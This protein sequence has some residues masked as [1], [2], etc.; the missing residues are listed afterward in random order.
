VADRGAH[1]GERPPLLDLEATLR[2]FAEARARL[3]L[4]DYD[5]TLV[6]F[7]RTPR[8]AL[9]PRGLVDVLERLAAMPSTRV[10][11]VSGRPRADLQRWFGHVPGL[12][13]A[14]EHG[15][16]IRRA[17]GEWEPLRAGGSTEWKARVRPVLEHFADRTPGSFIEEKEH[18][19]VWHYR[20]SDP[21]F[22]GW[23]AN[24][25]VHNLEQMLAETDRR[26]VRGH[27]AVE[28][29]P[30]WAHKGNVVGWLEDNGRAPDFRLG[31]GD[32]RTDE[33]LFENLPPDAWT[34][35]VGQGATRARFR[36]PDPWA[37]RAFLSE[38]ARA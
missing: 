7:A 22:G 32:D 37:V 10:C 34:V 18:G 31:M 15:A 6:P 30:V 12:W 25:L 28:V 13:L 23:V 11:V 19:L 24:E 20:L 29:R 33:D 38:L 4:L 26:A 5:G 27:K 16:L 1:A 21:E 8:E 3:L 17:S 9:P 2:A 14:A 35:H 36:L